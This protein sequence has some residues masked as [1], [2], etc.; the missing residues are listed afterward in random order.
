LTSP[1]PS[2]RRPQRALPSLFLSSAAAAVLAAAMT[3][4]APAAQAA[5]AAQTAPAAQA[6]PAPAP[7]G[8]AFS[9]RETAASGVSGVSGSGGTSGAS[10]GTAALPP[11]SLLEVVPV[12]PR[13]GSAWHALAPGRLASIP[14]RP[15]DAGTGLF[16]V[17]NVHG[18]WGTSNGADIMAANIENFRPSGTSGELSLSLWATSTVPVTSEGIHGFEIA[19]ADLGTLPAGDEFTNVDTGEIDF[20]PP[21]THACYYVSVVLLENNEVADIRTF[22][23]G[24]AQSAP[25]TNGYVVFSFLGGGAVCP[26]ATTCT[27]TATSA[28][29]LS[30]RFQV[31]VAYDNDTTGTGSGTVLAF[32]G[33]RAESDES[34]FFYF[35]DPSNFEIGAK[36]LDACTLTNTFWVFIGG[37]TNQ[38]WGLDILDTQTGNH[39]YYLNIDGTTTV[40]TAD[41]VGLPCP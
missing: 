9:V 33:T 17:G 20:S 10:A 34:V 1:K 3:A 12:Q 38:G 27:R 23:S 11:R 36:I 15:K 19:V 4:P 31:S 32:N 24:G 8:A 30:S 28:C 40:T 37:L 13:N 22:T 16:I 7:L 39:K 5:L 18:S 35:T 26:A 29:L 41:T 21:G 25:Q 6:A 2:A 14:P